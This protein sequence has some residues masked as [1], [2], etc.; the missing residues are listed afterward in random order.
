[1]AVLTKNHTD[2]DLVK[3][4][5]ASCL[6]AENA[7]TN[8]DHNTRANYDAYHMR[9]N[10]DHKSEGQSTEVLSKI[11]MSVESTKSFFQQ[12]LA[13]IGEWFQIEL[14]DPTVDEGAMLIKTH[15][16][17]ALLEYQLG[18]AGYFSHVGLSIQRALL[19]GILCTKVA[20]KLIPKPKFRTKTEGRGKSLK[21]SVVAVDDKTWRLEFSRI[22]NEDWYPDSL[23]RGLYKIEEIYM[24]LHEVFSHSKGDN[25]IYDLAAVEK[26]SKEYSM[27]G[28]DVKEKS[29]ETGQTTEGYQNAHRPQVKLKEYWG[30]VVSTDGQL[31]YENVVITV[32]NDTHIIRRPTP[33]PLWHQMTPFVTTSLLEV[34]GAVWPI[35]LMDAA[36]LHQK[37]MTE[38]LNLILD[39][40]FREVHA[41]SQLRV[42]DLVDPSQVSNGIP[43]GTTL[44]VK[45]TLPP[46]AKVYEPL[47]AAKVPA[48]ALNVLN[49]LQQEL[50]S[51]ALTT[52]LRQ[53]V[54]P[55][56]AVKATE[57]VESSQSIT[58][59][60]KGI[61]KNIEKAHI[62][63]E[64]ELAWMTIAQNLDMISVE[65]L[66]SLF[67]LKRGTELSQLDPQDVF[68]QTVN[69]FKFKVFGIEQTIAK[70]QDFR[71]LTTLLQTIS[72]SELLIEEFLKKYD[73]GKLV[74]EIMASLS[75][76][77]SKIAIPEQDNGPGVLRGQGS[78]DQG[79]QPL[80]DQASTPDAGATGSAF[81]EAFGQ[82]APG[83][84]GPQ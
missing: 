51:S 34:D 62:T 25:A 75:I 48:D 56:R 54:L 33:N 53:G 84:G 31:I 73:M 61:S 42:Q 15:E 69:G 65:E 2:A 9:H 57:V 70:A 36:T 58:S 17:Q 21:K 8:R 18:Q 7:R 68:V 45:S 38:M 1:M 43:A 23:G 27:Q 16:A 35:A 50:N 78:P 19:G 28:E 24:D 13:D 63:K 44:K 46:G 79:I 11:R 67:G 22:R 83:A 41:P 52:D 3:Y 76:D 40:A 80:P 37:T 6:D 59:V 81:M 60:F 49:L 74:G 66:Q 29:R 10:F 4:I 71:K 20:G 30:N 26:L 72:S 55:D 47:T 32:A 77:K 12:A 39:A 82:E 14:K 64:V 5:E